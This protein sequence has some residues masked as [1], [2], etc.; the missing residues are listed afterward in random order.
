MPWD[1]NL[2]PESK[3]CLRSKVMKF[4]IKVAF[5]KIASL[6]KTRMFFQTR[7][8]ATCV[9]DSHCNPEEIQC[10]DGSCVKPWDHYLCP[11]SEECLRSKVMKFQ[12]KVAFSKV[13]SMDKT[14]MFFQTRTNATCV[15]DSHCNPEEIQCADGSCV[16]PW[17]HNL[18]PESKECLRS[19][20]MKFQTKV[21]FS[22]VASLDKTRVFSNEEKCIVCF[23]LPLQ[24]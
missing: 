13:A 19:K 21:A 22:K 20:V 15:S 17:D 6:D 16:M 10:A 8:N 11:E 4:Q 12:I 18:C 14:R 24:P 3:E 1:H 23:R 7:T 2:C 5:S 9:S